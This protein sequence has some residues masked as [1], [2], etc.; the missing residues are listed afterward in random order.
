MNQIQTM[1]KQQLQK[2]LQSG[3]DLLSYNVMMLSDDAYKICFVNASLEL[4]LSINTL[5]ITFQ[6]IAMLELISQDHLS[7]RQT[8]PQYQRLDN[9]SQR[10]I[11]FQSLFKQSIQEVLKD[12]G[13]GSSS[14]NSQELCKQVNLCLELINKQ[15]FWNQLQQMIP[16]KTGKQLREYYQKTFSR[17]M[18]ED[19]TDED[20][21]QLL[22]RIYQND[23]NK[24]AALIANEF[25]QVCKHKNYFKRSITMTII[26]L[27]RKANQ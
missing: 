26:N 13:L 22:I 17:V 12:Y 21:R 5:H 10:H 15:I 23:P 25:M 20:D 11:D 16:E 6:D 14:K 7:L 19:L 1:L 24:R 9:R 18:Y 3:P 27:K 4:N 2:Q 8:V